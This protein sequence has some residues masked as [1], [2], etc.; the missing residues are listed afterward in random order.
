MHERTER[1]IA[2][3]LFVFCCAVPTLV[4]LLAILVSWTPWYHNRQRL[5]W[6]TELSLR[7]QLITQ[8]DDYQRASPNS[9]TFDG[10]RLLDPESGREV[11]RIRRVTWLDEGHRI[12]ISLHRPEIQSRM[13]EQAWS[14]VH[15]RFLCQPKLTNVPIQVAANDLKIK[16]QSVSYSIPTA[17]AAIAPRPNAVKA[18]LECLIENAK[19]PLVID[20]TRDR[21]V[22]D[23]IEPKTHWALDTGADPLPCSALADFF[24]L[25][26]RLGADAKFKGLLKWEVDNDGQWSIDLG[27]NST[28]TDIDVGHFFEVLPHRLTGTADLSFQRCQIIPKQKV[29]LV[30]SLRSQSGFIGSSLLRSMYKEMAVAVD[31]RLAES[32]IE[33]IPYDL[34]AFDFT[35]ID[36][37]LRVTGTCDRLD[38]GV[39]VMGPHGKMAQSS[40]ASIPSVQLAY[41]VSPENS[42]LVPVTRQTANM[43]DIFVPP[44]YAAEINETSD[45][46]SPVQRADHWAG[47]EVPAASSADH[48]DDQDS[49][50]GD[51]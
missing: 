13:L 20:V 21:G 7:T 39:I 23:S 37:D 33:N 18:V 35:M 32:H 8:I 30:G 16:S 5:R 40:G 46:A 47:D 31:L 41:A 27:K 4:V 42:E 51:R 19:S 24:P 43:L 6:Q 44:K 25:L 9:W 12:G 10:V 2:R 3:L 11:M 45:P 29:N 1:A 22:G 48:R 49:S 14:V 36:W 17:M 38:P 50:G 34:V 28:F 26:D 15:D